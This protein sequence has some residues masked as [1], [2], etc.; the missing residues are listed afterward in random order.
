MPRANHSR[1]NRNNGVIVTSHEDF[2]QNFDSIISNDIRNACYRL[3]VT[4]NR[5]RKSTLKKIAF[6]IISRGPLVKLNA[7]SEQYYLFVLDIIE[8]LLR[9]PIIG[10]LETLIFEKRVLKFLLVLKVVSPVLKI[11]AA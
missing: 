3:R 4:I 9:A 11:K 1:N 10:N 6:S 8:T 5:L 2:F 7:V